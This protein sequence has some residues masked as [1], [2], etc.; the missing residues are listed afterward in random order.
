MCEHDIGLIWYWR[1]S[2]RIWKHTKHPRGLEF[3]ASAASRRSL[4][5]TISYDKTYPFSVCFED[6][7]IRS[8][9]WHIYSDLSRVC[10]Q[11]QTLIKA[12]LSVVEYG[13][14][15]KFI[16]Q[17]VAKK[18][19]PRNIMFLICLM[20]CV[21]FVTGTV[22]FLCARGRP[23]D[24]L[25]NILINYWWIKTIWT[26]FTFYTKVI[27]FDKNSIANFLYYLFFSSSWFSFS[28]IVTLIL[29]I[30]NMVYLSSI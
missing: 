18:S 1:N 24:R 29:F 27:F 23:S 7:K 22:N 28:K 15:W 4:T 5:S 21:C 26:S 17:T 16:L 2:T 11:H 12:L 30:I 9:T 3:S 14:G 13:D 10:V 20:N 19:I 6:T 25:M 8:V